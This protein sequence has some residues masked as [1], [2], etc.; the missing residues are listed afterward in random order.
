MAVGTNQGVDGL[1]PRPFPLG[2][3]PGRIAPPIRRLQAV[4]NRFA[5]PLAAPTPLPMGKT[6]TKGGGDFKKS[7]QKLGKKKLAPTN[8]TNTAV[9]VL[10]LIHI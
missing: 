5:L 6:K 3:E 2:A 4:Q 10:S 9:K 1:A 7:K 8:A